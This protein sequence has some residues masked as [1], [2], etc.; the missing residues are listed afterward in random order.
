M[1]VEITEAIDGRRL[2]SVT[3]MLRTTEADAPNVRA[4]YELY[5]PEDFTIKSGTQALVLL[6]CVRTDTFEPV[7]LCKEQ[8]REFLQEAV[9]L[10]AEDDPDW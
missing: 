6:S 10:A 1:K 3:S 2:L 4:T 7:T 5:V 9:R 8:Q